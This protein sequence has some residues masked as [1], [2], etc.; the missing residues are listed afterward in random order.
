MGSP[1]GRGRLWVEQGP[2]RGDEAQ[3][4]PAERQPPVGMLWRCWLR[5]ELRGCGTVNLG[6]WL[7]GP[8]SYP[9]HHAS[10][11]TAYLR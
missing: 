5:R 7:F 1:A 4:G 10:D 6:E 11:V 2:V 9:W 8:W 3:F